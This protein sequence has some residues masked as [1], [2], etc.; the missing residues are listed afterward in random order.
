MKILFVCQHY[1]P[2]PFNV[3]EVCEELTRR[4][5]E[6]V[7]LTGL[8]NV[9]MP[10]NAIPEEYKRK[11]AKRQ[12]RN[13]VAIERVWL[14][15]RKIGAVNR[16]LNYLSFWISG[17]IRARKI[18]N[19]CDV[20]IGYQYSPIM[21]VDPGVSY[22]RRT[23]SPLL[24]SC[25][26]LWPESLTVG[27]FS[28]SSLAF[29]WMKKVSRRIYSEADLLA[30]TSESFFEYFEKELSLS[31][32]STVLLPQFAE[33]LFRNEVSPESSYDLEKINFT[34]AG[35]VGSGQSVETIVRAAS[36]LKDD[37]RIVFHIVGTGSSLS[38]CESLAEEL[39]LE[40]IVF[41]GRHP[42]ESMPSFYKAS[43]VMLITASNNEAFSYTLPRK[44]Q[45]YMASGKPIVGAIG[46]ESQ[47]VIEEAQCGLCCSAEDSRGLADICARM[48]ELPESDRADMGKRALSYF[49]SNYTKERF[50][51]LLEA[52]LE[53]LKGT[54]HGGC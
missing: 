26:D 41:H 5:H 47:R 1:W 19:D 46:G 15:P 18:A 39:C 9:G 25:F 44:I 40:N 12:E 11:A 8:P 37:N 45:S 38:N 24:V 36:R 53:K 54:K 35:N 42:L 3:N 17:R 49:E 2:E 43:D 6:V 22:A 28:R 51:S 31:T 52:E 29:R 27:G 10:G 4:G 34:F 7:V 33:N 14:W 23:G 16:V 20:V 13:G 21:Q 30:V 48:T 32:N 50:F